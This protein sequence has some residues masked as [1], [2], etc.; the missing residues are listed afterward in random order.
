MFERAAAMNPNDAETTGNLADAYRWNG[1]KEKSLATY[2]KAITLAY[3]E[4]QVNSKKA[5]TM[6]DLAGYYAKKGDRA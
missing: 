3:K 4:L 2:D 6:G 5:S 1:Q